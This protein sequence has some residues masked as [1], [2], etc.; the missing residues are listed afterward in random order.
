M[1]AVLSAAVVCLFL[2]TC[3]SAQAIGTVTLA[4]GDLHIIRGTTVSTAVQ[5]TRLRRGDILESSSRGLTQV[6]C[7]P[8]SVIAIGP[9]S[10]VFLFSESTSGSTRAELVLLSGWLKAETHARA[11]TYQ[12]DTPW[13]AA[14]ASRGTVV[15]R[16]A[17]E[18]SDIFVESG[19]ASVAEVGASGITGQF[20]SAKGGEFFSRRAGKGLAS[21]NGPADNFV[22]SMP[23]AFKDTLPP[24]LSLAGRK[25]VEPGRGREIE[26]EQLRP[27]LVMPARWRRD[28]VSRFESRLDDPKFR[29]GIVAHLH[30][31]PEWEPALHPEGNSTNKQ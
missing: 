10:K 16:A 31:H 11:G 30:D 17:S 9:S 26:Y 15:L 14:S 5:G 19:S 25:D 2:A 3:A 18:S 20:R 6:E 12:F 21:S 7:G 4:E 23:N 13:L 22:Q 28:F 8:E 29:Q 1:R 24:R 27:Y